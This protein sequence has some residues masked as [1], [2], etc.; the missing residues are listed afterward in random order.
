MFGIVVGKV[1]RML[2]TISARAQAQCILGKMSL[3]VEGWIRQPRG[4]P[5][6]WESE[7]KDHCKDRLNLDCAK[8][9]KLTVV[10]YNE[11]I[12]IISYFTYEKK[13]TNLVAN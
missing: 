12:S 5:S 9:T 7:K 13:K 11:Y 4:D 6:D 8:P 1:K 2:S 10:V 3:V